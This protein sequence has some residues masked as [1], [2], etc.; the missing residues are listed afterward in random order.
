MKWKQLVSIL[1][2]IAIG[3]LT[4]AWAAKMRGFT[5]FTSLSL[6]LRYAS[7][8]CFVS[9]VILCGIGSLTMI[10]TTGF[11]DIFAYCAASL[12]SHISSIWKGYEHVRYYDYKTMRAE[13]RGKS[14]AFILIIGLGFLAA[15]VLLLL[16]YH[17]LE[18][19]IN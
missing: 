7:D 8:G 9:A 10:A 2:T 18:Q 16:A 13:K 5:G 14:L 17:R 19:N 6:K 12:W 15:S 11:F 1:I 3:L 4:A